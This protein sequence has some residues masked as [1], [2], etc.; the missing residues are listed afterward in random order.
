MDGLRNIARRIAMRLR[1]GNRITA[2]YRLKED[3]MTQA[4]LDSYP[5]WILAYQVEPLRAVFI[6]ANMARLLEVPPGFIRTEDEYKT[7]HHCEIIT[8][9]NRFLTCEYFHEGGSEA[10]EHIA[11]IMLPDDT[12]VLVDDLAMPLIADE[13]GK[14][15]LYAHFFAERN[16]PSLAN[17][18]AFCDPD[19][20]TPKQLEVFLLLLQRW[21]PAQISR[22]LQIT[23][24]T[25]AN[26]IAAILELTGQPHVTALIE[27]CGNSL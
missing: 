13:S 6:S 3:G 9:Y 15:T 11:T 8:C 24:K 19:S 1:K 2:D 22:H 27:K 23:P 5:A 16:R 21:Q 20:L 14:T 18:Y 12:P 26:H 17:A 7:V 25:L 4:I 10:R